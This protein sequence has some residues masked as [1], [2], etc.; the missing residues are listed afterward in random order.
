M[1]QYGTNIGE[2]FEKG[3]AAIGAAANF[4]RYTRTHFV[5]LLFA[6]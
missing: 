4:V 2:N 6:S 1:H 5:R 3:Y